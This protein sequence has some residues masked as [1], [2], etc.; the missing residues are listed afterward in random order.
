M[1]S[2]LGTRLGHY[3]F[4]DLLGK[5]GMGE[6]YVGYD[7]T[8]DRRVALK[9]LHAGLH[10][11][12]ERKSRFLREARVLS[13]LA[14]PNICQ[15][16]DYLDSEQTHVLVLELIQGQTLTQARQR[17][18]DPRQKLLIAE[19]IA[20]ALLAAHEKGIIHRDLK[21]DNV[22]LTDDLQVKVLDF[23][24]SRLQDE[25]PPL[26]PPTR[27]QAPA[28]A[29]PEEAP[30][31]AAA[32]TLPPGFDPPSEG[33]PEPGTLASG[34]TLRVLP[35]PG[36]PSS[37]Y[38][39]LSTPNLTVLGTIMGTPGYMSPEQARG[40]VTTAA[41]DQ[42]SFGVLLQELFTG[43]PPFEPGLEPAVLLRRM[44]RGET[45]P[46]EGVEADLEALIRRLKAPAP[47]ARPSSLDT[48]ERL[49]W[50]RARPQRRQRKI[51]QGAAMAI[52]LLFGAA[53]T[54]QTVRASRA[55]RATRQEAEKAKAVADF[56]LGIF[57]VS[58]P[59]EARGNTV[60]ARELLDQGAA[61]IEADLH[62]QPRVQADLMATM[63]VV[64]TKL[65]LYAQA[66][67][68]LRASLERR[69]R[70]L[71][72]WHPD[73]AQ[74]L[75]GLGVLFVDL[76]Q[77]GKAE[78]LLQRSLAIREQALGPGN[79]DVANSLGALAGLYRRQGRFKEA[80]PLYQRSRALWERAPQA[81]PRDLAAALNSLALLYLDQNQLALA[82]P[83]FLRSL[84][85]WEGALG[86][87]HPELANVNNNL[88]LLYERKGALPKAEAL[89]QRALAIR[90]KNLGPGH[91]KTA[92]ACAN[93]AHCLRGQ[94]KLA[95]AELLFNRSLAIY[96]QALGPD[97]V[98]PNVANCLDGLGQVYYLQGR[99]QLA[100]DL[101]R[102]CLRINEQVLG[103]RSEEA[104]G[105][106][107]N[108]GCVS[109]KMGRRAEAL[110]FLHRTLAAWNGAPW[111]AS[112]A[113]D[114]DLAALRGDPEFT[115]MVAE[116]GRKVISAHPGP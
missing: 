104:V 83:L 95:Q 34:A 38:A 43:R 50:I 75:N 49:A 114:D 42:F 112:M 86:P 2:L 89:F 51:L 107:Y 98:N 5:G 65:G 7:E 6:V 1:S 15:I 54:V 18:L 11:S 99:F 26:A 88:A 25:G 105:N 36:G 32:D 48:V 84:Q 82:E 103:P 66:E 4:L 80:E 12:P 21:P 8:L 23:G 9:V 68:L 100:R 29:S 47:A 55:E 44:Q 76:G 57:Q 19:Q 22:M 97:P 67:P 90:E 58:D 93:L 27:T 101:F 62:S 59:D 77:Y 39:A 111:L 79:P 35:G 24:L 72:P 52:L 116:V 110:G 28:P 45:L 17:G 113:T 20:G 30:G 108:L 41:S 85:L 102:R 74:S 13:Q 106:L 87:D 37:P 63:G 53:M 94:G 70:L 73:L 46:V 3:Q 31:F 16:F 60:T 33:D 10:P 78:P 69:E 56:L 115:R 96:E 109:A 40:E 14:H 64:Y 61:R 71:G 81:H 92:M 91:P